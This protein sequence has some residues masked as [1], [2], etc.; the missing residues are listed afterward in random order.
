MYFDEFSICF[1]YQ[2]IYPIITIQEIAPHRIMST[3]LAVIT[4]LPASS[5]SLGTCLGVSGISIELLAANNAESH[6]DK[7]I[8]SNLS[9]EKEDGTNLMTLPLMLR[10]RRWWSLPKLSGK[11][12][13]LLCEIS[14]LTSLAKFTSS[15]GKCLIWLCEMFR[16]CNVL[17]RCR[18]LH[19]PTGR[20][21]SWLCEKLSSERF[22]SW[23][24]FP[25]ISQMLLE[26]RSNLLRCFAFRILL[27]T[28]FK[29]QPLKGR[30]KHN[31]DFFKLMQ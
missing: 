21:W 31:A 16:H 1:T 24:R 2:I 19:S 13:R 5:T 18:L 11:V 4:V 10:K 20:Y 23:S 30:G 28:F 26:L 27:S 9:F 29:L 17:A 6:P 7:S 22:V 12:S 14:N 3:H 15:K 8:S 25:G